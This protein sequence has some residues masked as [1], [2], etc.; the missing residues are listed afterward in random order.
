VCLRARTVNGPRSTPPASLSSTP[1][2][3][4]SSH[5]TRTTAK[6]WIAVTPRVNRHPPRLPVV[7]PSPCQPGSKPSALPPNGRH[8]C[9][10]VQRGRPLCIR[11][12]GHCALV[13]A[14]HT[15]IPGLRDL[16]QARI[17][18]RRSCTR[19]PRSVMSAWWGLGAAGPAHKNARVRPASHAAG[20]AHTA[21]S[22]FTM[23][24]H[25]AKRLARQRACGARCLA[26]RCSSSNS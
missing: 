25:V 2:P 12:T 23:S 11:V 14:G 18:A 22:G 10:A 9:R 21:G 8:T 6:L 7:P 20:A 4:R 13:P 24:S 5:G 17:A 26:H 19:L 16:T 3:R 1:S 15:Q